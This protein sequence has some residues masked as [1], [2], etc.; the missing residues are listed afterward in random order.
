[1]G[2][3]ELYRVESVCYLIREQVPMLKAD[4]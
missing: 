1:V 3:F 4:F 2:F